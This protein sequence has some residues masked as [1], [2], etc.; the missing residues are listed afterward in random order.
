[1]AF[2]RFRPTTRLGTCSFLPVVIVVGLAVDDV[3]SGKIK[4][5]KAGA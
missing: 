2:S 5:V 4:V 1:M 3:C